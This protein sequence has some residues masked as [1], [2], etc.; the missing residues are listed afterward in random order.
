[1]DAGIYINGIY[2]AYCSECGRLINTENDKFTES[3]TEK[4]FHGEVYEYSYTNLCDFCY[5]KFEFD[6]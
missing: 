6:F 3:E 1:M 2:H 5:K 4:K